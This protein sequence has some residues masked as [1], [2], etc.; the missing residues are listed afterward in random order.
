MLVVG[1]GVKKK[2]VTRGDAT[3]FP[4]PLDHV[5]IRLKSTIY[6]H[7]KIVHKEPSSYLTFQS[8]L[9]GECVHVQILEC[10]GI[11][12]ADF[13]GTS[14]PYIV[15]F[16]N[17]RKL[18]ITRV[19]PRTLYPRWNNETIVVPTDENL[20]PSRGTSHD[21]VHEICMHVHVLIQTHV[22]TYIDKHTHA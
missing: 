18:G 21:H 10:R 13:G 20:P 7:G 22:H 6:N 3:S 15:S 1:P 17:G 12:A 16:Y 14:D 8:G 11:P 2:V 4:M 19:K 9:S 5:T